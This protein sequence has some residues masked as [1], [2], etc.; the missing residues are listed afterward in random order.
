[1]LSDV[2]GIE[3]MKALH[4]V[5]IYEEGKAAFRS[6]NS[7]FRKQH[8]KKKSK[9]L[10]KRRIRYRYVYR[11]TRLA[12]QTSFPGHN[13]ECNAELCLKLSQSLLLSGL[14]KRVFKSSRA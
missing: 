1:M 5:C 9:D 11:S 10:G 14:F 8:T 7:H 6:R 13:F 12:R 3:M 4:I 2:Y